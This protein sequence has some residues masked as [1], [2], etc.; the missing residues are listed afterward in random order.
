MTHEQMRD[1][2]ELVRSGWP[3]VV[4]LLA[5]MFWRPLAGL[6]GSLGQIDI[7]GFGLQVKLDR[8]AIEE[9]K[10]TL[11]RPAPRRSQPA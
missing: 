1:L 10:K 9:T 5:V 2:A 6:I 11:T 7:S 4:L 3:I 8:M